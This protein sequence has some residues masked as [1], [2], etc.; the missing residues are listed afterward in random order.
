MRLKDIGEERLIR[1][2]AE[3]FSSAHPRLTK[4]IGDD[5]SVSTQAKD[6]SLLVTTDLLI[7]GTHFI[8]S[9]TTAYLLGRKA[10]SISLSDIAAMGGAPLF[11]LVSVALPPQTRKTFVDELYK[12]LHACAS[13]FGAHLA[14]GNTAANDR[15]MVSTTV[16]GEAD[17]K[18][19]VYRSG[20]KAGDIIYVTGTLGD[21]ALGL[22]VLSKNSLKKAMSG[23]WAEAVKKHLDPTPRLIAGKLLAEGGLASAMMDISD[24]LGLDLERLCAQS[25]AGALVELGLLPVSGEVDRYA[26]GSEGALIRLAVSGGEDY[27]LLF[28]SPEKNDNRIRRL[29]KRLSVPITRIGRII[30]YDEHGRGR[31]RVAFTDSSR[32]AIRIKKAGFVHF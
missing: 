12:G 5:T 20:G 2:L 27:E 32:K 15:I 11:Y 17:P 8:K 9:R 25:G 26:S 16:I 7:E 6:R 23:R 28:T 19:V 30:G 3:R 1:E 21:S 22:E 31:R 24:G 13:E 4:A 14:G 29:A 18:K 10:L